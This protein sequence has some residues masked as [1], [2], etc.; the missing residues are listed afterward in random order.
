MVSELGV[1]HRQKEGS[2]I[3]DASEKCRNGNRILWGSPGVHSV[4]GGLEDDLFL[5]SH[6]EGNQEILT[7]VGELIKPWWKASGDYV[8]L[9]PQHNGV[10]GIKEA[11]LFLQNYL[12]SET[13]YLM[14]GKNSFGIGD[15][16]RQTKNDYKLNDGRGVF[17][18]FVGTV[19]DIE[20]GK[21]LIVDFDGEFVR[22]ETMEQMFNLTL[23]Y[24]VSVHASQGSGY[25]KGVIIADRSH[26]FM[27]NRQLIYVALSRFKAECHVVGQKKTVAMAIRKNVED[28]RNTFLGDELNIVM[29]LL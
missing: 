15:R 19:V 1:C 11:N 29:K 22:Y 23:G 3:A 12:N 7:E 2:L 5:H 24:V 8:V 20:A 17:N 10:V 4:E 26:V 9:S 27:W 6:N 14:V 18:G 28:V 25:K 21:R 16:V 13:N